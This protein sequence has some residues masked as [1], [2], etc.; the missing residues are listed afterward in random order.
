MST[1]FAGQTLAQPATPAAA[2]PPVTADASI[3]LIK[4]YNADA[5]P[6]VSGPAAYLTLH[7]NGDRTQQVY[8]NASAFGPK[9]ARFELV[10]SIAAKLGGAITPELSA[11]LLAAN[12]TGLPYGYWALVGN[13]QKGFTICYQVEIAVGA[14]AATVQEVMN[15]VALQADALEAELMNNK[16]D[17]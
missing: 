2:T 3:A 11:R 17:L 6:G 4:L 12:S 5:S 1:A 7:A 8:V 15:T 14:S 16:D 9:S 10:Y 13:A